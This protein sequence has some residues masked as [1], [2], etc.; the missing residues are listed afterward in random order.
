MDVEPTSVTHHINY[1]S[2]NRLSEDT[3]S[4]VDILEKF[5]QGVSFDFL[6]FEFGGSVIEIKGYGTLAQFL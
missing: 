2:I 6:C 1:F 3:S 4:G 5:L